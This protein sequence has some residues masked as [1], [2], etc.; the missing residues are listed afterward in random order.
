[1]CAQRRWDEEAE[2]DAK[3]H[4]TPQVSVRP[5]PRIMYQGLSQ[6][7]STCNSG[8]LCA[9][10]RSASIRPINRSRIVVEVRVI[11]IK[12]GRLRGEK[13]ERHKPPKAE[14]Q[15]GAHVQPG[16]IPACANSACKEE[17]ISQECGSV[18]EL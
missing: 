17:P 7:D 9:S 16:D 13:S 6:L 8:T 15:L 10:Q 12:E 1:M 3:E 5:I 14:E 11:I 4:T 2:G 18:D